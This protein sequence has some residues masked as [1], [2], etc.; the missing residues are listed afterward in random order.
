MNDVGYS[1]DSLMLGFGLAFYCAKAKELVS[2]R[3]T[4]V[5]VMRR[6]TAGS[7]ART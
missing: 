1:F 3:T 2:S 4:V 5:K 6:L 7:R